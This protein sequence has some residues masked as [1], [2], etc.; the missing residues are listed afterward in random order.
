MQDTRLGNNFWHQPMTMR[1]C[2][3]IEN[4]E[5]RCPSLVLSLVS[6]CPPDE[7]LRHNWSRI[8]SVPSSTSWRTSKLKPRKKHILSFYTGKKAW[9]RLIHFSAVTH[10]LSSLHC[11]LILRDPIN[12]KTAKKTVPV[13]KVIENTGSLLVHWHE[14]SRYF[15][16]KFYE[17]KEA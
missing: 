3:M 10:C 11:T 1:K 17:L 15:R 5:R 12:N 16:P 8:L 6:D 2:H 9:Y 14:I 13:N 4:K 7:P